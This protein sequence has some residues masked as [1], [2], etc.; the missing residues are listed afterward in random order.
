MRSWII[1]ATIFAASLF[2]GLAIITSTLIAER[3]NAAARVSS[4]PWPGGELR[5]LDRS[6]HRQ[7]LDRALDRIGRAGIEFNLRLV[8]P[9][10]DPQLTISKLSKEEIDKDCPGCD[11][12]A[13]SIGYRGQDEEI[14]FSD[15]GLDRA[16]ITE[17]F[18]HEIGHILGLE[19]T[20]RRCSVMQPNLAFRH[21]SERPRWFR[22]G[23]QS[24][25]VNRLLALGYKRRHTA[26]RPWCSMASY[27]K[28]IAPTE[29]TANNIEVLGN[30]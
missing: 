23:L 17:L 19:H 6:G 20:T 3:G 2:I 25:D 11:G 12:V 28:D 13:S 10:Q 26:Y 27:I 1:T 24:Y 5:I 4:H 15:Q 8:G 16:S 29:L 7:E 30:P 9:D 21:C 22:C 18:V 14:V